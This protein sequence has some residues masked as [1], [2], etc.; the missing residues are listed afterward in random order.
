MKILSAVF[1]TSA[2]DLASCPPSDLPEIAFVGRSNVG[3]SSVINMLT[4]RKNLANISG[5]P[6]KTRFINF[7]TIDESWSIVDL[8]GYGYAKTSKKERGRFSAVIAD[9]LQHRS[10]LVGTFVL[11]DS[12]LR[13]QKIDL[14][15][16]QWMVDCE[17]PFALA[18]TK[19]DRISGAAAKQ[20]VEAFLE[21]FQKISA[22]RPD[23]L[24]TSSK[25][26]TGRMEM[27]A[28]IDAAL[29]EAAEAAE[30]APVAENPNPAEE[31]P[32]VGVSEGFGH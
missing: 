28:L 32:K 22:D 25:L 10:N 6:G 14:E 29:S 17:L 31:E 30:A 18:F 26:R 20:N 9:Y 21:H 7:F 16:L 13:P 15:F 27:L 4:N 12:M 23:V 19:V 8:P 2:P 11:I 1:Q 24:F 5:A 3:K